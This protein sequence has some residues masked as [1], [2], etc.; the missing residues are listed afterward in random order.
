M[1]A[2]YRR[3]A[4]KNPIAPTISYF[5]AIQRKIIKMNTGMLCISKP[6]KQ[7]RKLLQESKTSRENIAKNNMNMIEIILGVQY[8]QP[9]FM[10]LL[11]YLDL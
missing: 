11:I 1:D 9:F 10:F 4:R 7:L 3:P 8:I 2:I 6:R 5:Q